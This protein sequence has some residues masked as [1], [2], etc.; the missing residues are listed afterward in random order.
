[1][2]SCKFRRSIA[3]LVSFPMQIMAPSDEKVSTRLLRAVKGR[4]MLSAVL[5]LSG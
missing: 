2:L 5:I 3:S 1:M 4:L